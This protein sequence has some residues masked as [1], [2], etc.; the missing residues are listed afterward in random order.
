[1]NSSASFLGLGIRTSVLGFPSSALAACTMMSLSSSCSSSGRI[2]ATTRTDIFSIG[3]LNQDELIERRRRDSEV[4]ALVLWSLASAQLRF[5]SRTRSVPWDEKSV[6]GCGVDGAP[7]QGVPT[8]IP[9]AVVR[10]NQISNPTKRPLTTH[11]WHT[12]TGGYEADRVTYLDINNTI[13]L[14]QS[15]GV[16]EEDCLRTFRASGAPV[17]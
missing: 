12:K 8:P 9:L 16:N 1:V 6:F 4:I 17:G 5:A 2:L 10:G 7:G 3:Q 15:H 14:S 11:Y 13:K